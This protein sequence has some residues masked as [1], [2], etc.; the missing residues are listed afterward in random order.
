M[1]ITL[2]KISEVLG[3]SIST[4]SR[5]LQNH[6]DISINTRQ[7]V[8]ELAAVL[9]YEPNANAINLRKQNS[10]V[11][12]LMVPSVANSF[13]G[14]FMGAIEEHCQ[15]AG[16]SL[17]IMQS[18]DN[19]D[20]EKNIL[21]IYR[22]NRVAGC[23]ACLAPGS[24]DM[25]GF[26][27]LEDLDIPVVFFDKVPQEDNCNKVYIDNVNA[28]HQAANALISEGKKNILTLYGSEQLAI[29]RQRKEAFTEISKAHPQVRLHA[30][31]A[32]TAQEATEITLRYFKEKEK[33]DAIF[34]M[35]DEILTGAMKSL[36]S[37]NIKY[38][39]EVGIIAMSDG[40][41]PGLYHP[42]VTYVET[43]GYKLGKKAYQMM[44]TCMADHSK[45]EEQLVT[46][47]L[48]KGGSL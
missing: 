27:K 11:F 44:E 6:P 14:S 25:S 39:D 12:G 28:A 41:Y 26:K 21:K 5:A 33:P 18:G 37:L 3:L 47:T 19:A 43:S 10:K 36:Q 48:I 2:K 40:Y 32:A 17:I 22:Q 7:K 4:V 45:T 30:E 34:C 1:N 46:T 31:N 8:V 16:Y 23:F 24:N 13:Y 38:P 29:S 20:I 42:V 35:S 9:D 15:Q